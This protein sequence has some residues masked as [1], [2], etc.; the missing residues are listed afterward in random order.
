MIPREK[1][2]Y[3]VTTMDENSKKLNWEI[4]ERDA[5]TKVEAYNQFL[6]Q[7]PRLTR[8]YLAEAP[9]STKLLDTRRKYGRGSMVA[10]GAIRHEFRER[11]Y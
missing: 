4:V 9:L 1:D 7:T 2:R 11:G 5:S 6:S 3:F 10:L 8:R